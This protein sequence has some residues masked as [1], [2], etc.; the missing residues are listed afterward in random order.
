MSER[1]TK[2]KEV[3][4]ANLA[5]H[6]AV[7]A[8]RQVASESFEPQRID[9]LKL[10]RKSAVYRLTGAGENGS[11]V[12]AKRCPLHTAAIERLIYEEFLPRLPLTSL[13]YYGS[14]EELDGEF[15]WLF[16]EEA[17][18]EM[19]SPLNAEHRVLAGRWLAAVHTAGRRHLWK[20][21]LPARGPEQHLPMLR[22]CRAK[23]LEHLHN[24]SLSSDGAAVLHTVSEQCETLET[25]WPEVEA[26]CREV[27]HTLIHGDFV[28]KNLRV[29]S[30]AGG[31]E[32][33]VY[34]WEFAGWGEPFIDLAQFT[35]RVASPD[36]AIYRSCVEG[37]PNIGDEAQ[38][39]RWAECG[40]L[41]RLVDIMYWTS[42]DLLEGP[43]KFLAG[44]LRNFTMYS[45]RLAGALSAAGWATHVIGG[46]KSAAPGL[47]SAAAN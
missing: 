22:S 31:P 25:H 32:L 28:V 39:Q 44:P 15:S 47:Q 41:F 40:R 26:F 45:Q 33:L 5:E 21:R 1:A 11:T 24:P 36:L 14:V 8:W 38:V 16:M 43:P 35:G 2:F 4:P 12:I 37:S 29:R 6:R 30:S 23:V 20:G 10:K 34:D 27:S 13:R 3:L 42:L 18:G 7:K 46:I 9:I 17:T 19:Y